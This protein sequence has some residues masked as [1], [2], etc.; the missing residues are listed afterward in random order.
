M[1]RFAGTFRRPQTLKLGGVTYLQYL[2]WSAAA[3]EY[4]VDK[5]ILKQQKPFKKSHQV[6]KLTK[7]CHPHGIICGHGN[8]NWKDFL[9]IFP[10]KENSE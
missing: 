3:A 10:S 2:R 9:K 5:Y 4:F 7:T 6:K 8:A 1:K